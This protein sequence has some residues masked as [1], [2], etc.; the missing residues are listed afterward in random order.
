MKDGSIEVKDSEQ[1][2]EKETKSNEDCGLQVLLSALIFIS[3][4]QTK[5][6]GLISNMQSLRLN[7]LRGAFIENSKEVGLKFK[8][9][10]EHLFSN[11]I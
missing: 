6:H 2:E 11:I 4:K 9:M 8:F 1:E 7:S 10:S 3:E 5:F